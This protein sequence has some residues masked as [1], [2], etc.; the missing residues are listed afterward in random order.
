RGAAA[1]NDAGTGASYIAP[2]ADGQAR[3]IAAAHR[4]SGVDP[5]SVSY[6]EAHGTATTLGDPI[7]VEGLTRTYREHTRERQFCALGSVKSNIGH[8]SAASGVA[9][10]MKTA[11]AMQ[12]R[13]LPASLHFRDPNPKLDLENSPFYVVDSTRAWES[14]E[15][16]RAGVSAFGVGGINAH[17]ILESFD[18]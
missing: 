5:R 10:L 13:V 7:E 8:T 11:L 12:H 4:V 6:V 1:N 2:S 14:A 3:V 17:V 18:S 16:L 9:G 15:P